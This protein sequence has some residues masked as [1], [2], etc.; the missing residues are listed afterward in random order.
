MSRYA[1]GDDT[2]FGD[3]Y[4]ALAPRLYRMLLRATKDAELTKDV[5]QDTFVKIH[6]RR[7]SFIIGAN[8]LPW[9]RQ[10]AKRVLLNELRRLKRVPVLEDEQ[11]LDLLVAEAAQHR[12]AEAREIMPRLAVLLRKLSRS[13]REA[14]LLVRYDGLTQAE[15]AEILQTSVAGIKC[16]LQRVTDALATALE[17]WPPREPST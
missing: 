12:A 3:L 6:C 9:V 10:I 5:L 17:N 2:A 8:V 13:Q 1:L 14:L 15:A 7:G 4:D 16:R 11:L